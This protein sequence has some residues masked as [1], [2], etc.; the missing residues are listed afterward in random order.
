[1]A[2]TAT[3]YIETNEFVSDDAA[4]L[5]EETRAAVGELQAIQSAFSEEQR[6]VTAR[7]SKRIA[8]KETIELFRAFGSAIDLC[9]LRAIKESK[10]YRNY[11]HTSEDGTVHIIK[12]WEQFCTLVEEKSAD[13]IDEAL[14][15]LDKHGEIFYDAMHR[16]GIGPSLMRD[17]R[18]IPP[19]ARETLITIAERGEAA[20]F[21]EYAADVIASHQKE[22]EALKAEKESLQK[23]LDE[24]E[25]D[26]KARARILKEKNER[27]DNLSAELGRAREAIINPDWPEV[28]DPLIRKIF[29]IQCELERNLDAI[30]VMSIEAARI[31][32]S[33]KTE[34]NELALA[35][36][37]RYLAEEI[38][39]TLQIARQKVEKAEHQFQRTVGAWMPE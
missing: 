26:L 21:R 18:D 35:K 9:D 38:A 20:A 29:E 12:T 25:G 16:I 2:R 36:V 23:Q 30:E 19:D 6:A 33:E 7:I 37:K 32:P 15:N 14:K 31:E 3:P 22:K 27:I 1:M 24:K 34:A 11:Q 28:F 17:L 5:P 39:G 8:R 4:G 13:T 10:Q